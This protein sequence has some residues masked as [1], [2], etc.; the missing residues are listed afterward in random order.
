MSIVN[1][2]LSVNTGNGTNI[3]T[4]P[5]SSIKITPVVEISN[6]IPVISPG[7]PTATRICVA[8]EVLFLKNCS[9]SIQGQD[10]PVS[11][12]FIPNIAGPSYPKLVNSNFNLDVT[13]D[14]TNIS[15]LD[16]SGC[17]FDV[18]NVE[19]NS[20]NCKFIGN[21]NL[22]VNMKNTQFNYNGSVC[23]SSVP[24]VQFTDLGGNTIFIHQLQPNGL[25]DLVE[26]INILSTANLFVHL[27]A[28]HSPYYLGTVDYNYNFVLD[29]NVVITNSTFTQTVNF[30]QQSY[31]LDFSGCIFNVAYDDNVNKY[32]CITN[33][34]VK[35]YNQCI[36][37]PS[38]SMFNSGNLWNFLPSSPSNPVTIVGALGLIIEISTGFYENFN[39][40]NPQF[41]QSG[42]ATFRLIGGN[43]AQQYSLQLGSSNSGL[44]QYPINLLIDNKSIASKFNISVFTVSS[45]GICNT[46]SNV[47]VDF[48][49][50]N[51]NNLLNQQSPILPNLSP[52]SKAYSY[53]LIDNNSQNRNITLHGGFINNGQNIISPTFII[54]G[55]SDAQYYYQNSNGVIDLSREHYSLVN[56]SVT[57]SFQLLALSPPVPISMSIPNQPLKEIQPLMKIVQLSGQNN[58]GIVNIRFN[59]C[60]FNDVM[61]LQQS[62]NVITANVTFTNTDFNYTKI[63]SAGDS[64]TIF[65][66]ATNNTTAIVDISNCHINVNQS[67]LFSFTQSIPQWIVGNGPSTNGGD[68]KSYMKMEGCVVDFSGNE[69]ILLDNNTL[70]TD[71]LF[72]NNTLNMNTFYSDISLNTILFN[73]KNRFDASNIININ[74]SSSTLAY[75]NA[76]IDYSL[77]LAVSKPNVNVQFNHNS[78]NEFVANNSGI[79]AL[80]SNVLTFNPNAA[81]IIQSTTL[82]STNS[83]C[84]PSV[85]FKSNIV[86]TSFC[87][88][89]ISSNGGISPKIIFN[90]ATPTVF[91]ILPKYNSEKQ[92]LTMD[93]SANYV[94]S[95]PFSY[96]L[97]PLLPEGYKIILDGR[98]IYDNFDNDILVYKNNIRNLFINKTVATIGSVGSYDISG[99]QYYYTLNFDTDLGANSPTVNVTLPGVIIND[100]N[101]SIHTV[102]LSGNV[103]LSN[104]PSVS[105]LDTA[106]MLNLQSSSKATINMN[107]MTLSSLGVT[108]IPIQKL[109]KIVN[110]SPNS[111]VSTSVMNYR[112]DNMN[113]IFQLDPILALPNDP[114]NQNYYNNLANNYVN[115][116]ATRNLTIDTTNNTYQGLL[117]YLIINNDSV[118]LT[119]NGNTLP[120]LTTVQPQYVYWPALN[121]IAT[122]PNYTNIKAFT[123][124]AIKIAE[125]WEINTPLDIGNYLGTNSDS[126][127]N[128]KY[129]KLNKYGIIPTT[130]NLD[131]LGVTPVVTVNETNGELSKVNVLA[132]VDS[133][134]NSGVLSLENKINNNNT[135]SHTGKL[136]D[137]DTATVNNISNSTN[138]TMTNG[139]LNKKVDFATGTISNN[140]NVLVLFATNGSP[141]LANNV[142]L[143]LSLNSSPFKSYSSF[144]KQTQDQ[145][146]NCSATKG[147]NITVEQYLLSN[148]RQAGYTG[149]SGNIIKPFDP[150]NPNEPQANSN[151]TSI[152]ASSA[153][154]V[155][156]NYDKNITAKYSVSYNYDFVPIQGSRFNFI[157]DVNVDI[158]FNTPF[159]TINNVVGSN[160]SQNIPNIVYKGIDNSQV[161]NTTPDVIVSLNTIP[162]TPYVTSYFYIKPI[163]SSYN[164]STYNTYPTELTRAIPVNQIY[165]IPLDWLDTTYN[166]NNVTTQPIP[167]DGNNVVLPSF[168]IFG[169]NVYSDISYN[170]LTQVDTSFN[171]LTGERIYTTCNYVAVFILNDASP[172]PQASYNINNDITTLLSTTYSNQNPVDINGNYKRGDI[173]FE[174]Y[175][176]P[177]HSGNTAQVY[178]GDGIVYYYNTIYRYKVTMVIN[179]M[180]DLPSTPLTLT[181]SIGGSN[182]PNI[183]QNLPAPAR[184]TASRFNLNNVLIP[185]YI[186][187]HVAPSTNYS[188][189]QIWND[190]ST[191]NMNNISWYDGGVNKPPYT[192]TLISSGL[193]SGSLKP[194]LLNS[195]NTFDMTD[196]INLNMNQVLN[197][198]GNRN[199]WTNGNSN[200]LNNVSNSSVKN[201]GSDTSYIIYGINNESWQFTPTVS[202]DYIVGNFNILATSDPSCNSLVNAQYQKRTSTYSYNDWSYGNPDIDD[203]GFIQF[204]VGKSLSQ[205]TS[206]ETTTISSFDLSANDTYK[207]TLQNSDASVQPQFSVAATSGQST[208][209]PYN[210]FTKYFIAFNTNMAGINID[211]NNKVILANPTITPD[212]AAN[213][214][215]TFIFTDNN[216][217]PVS[218]IELYYGDN[219]PPIK[220]TDNKFVVPLDNNHNGNPSYKWYNDGT[221]ITPNMWQYVFFNRISYGPS[222]ETDYSNL[223]VN[224]TVGNASGNPSNTKNLANKSLVTVDYSKVGLVSAN[225]S[226]VF[227][228][229]WRIMPSGDGQSLLFRYATA[230]NNPYDM[231]L[232]LDQTNTSVSSTTYNNGTLRHISVPLPGI[233]PAQP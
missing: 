207:L 53:A 129:N 182:G 138:I 18:D 176:T 153:N 30:D 200:G 212:P 215:I 177:S 233:N 139:W 192:I 55:A 109:V 59:N 102:N 49:N 190:A 107:S 69:T 54:S 144:Y 104:S 28:A 220:S 230:G 75:T 137:G 202:E 156:A 187:I 229:N 62:T 189:N 142:T 43:A 42:N 163:L 84:F 108:R 232:S 201:N 105:I 91:N 25:N 179:N 120:T 77:K 1:L 174:R 191:Y 26:P 40:I 95:I 60:I 197:S 87:R 193:L 101:T 85:N 149:D 37:R 81:T 89:Y 226:Q 198:T 195:N 231:V 46:G 199:S 106:M 8:Y 194:L 214:T 154:L 157:G 147:V 7:I 112:Y 183:P 10:K 38:A 68:T 172:S 221:P 78:I 88:Q 71:Y 196:I 100:T 171:P 14:S 184:T 67:N 20:S 178:P 185:L 161:T 34:N 124:S 65:N 33:G 17:L 117:K 19:R 170:K 3:Y 205:T 159:F 132:V 41:Q 188:N 50:M 45:V 63:I 224:Y 32:E 208:L 169:V 74:N 16:M 165:T 2:N 64:P 115:M 94:N 166:T 151:K 5:S 31:L 162:N 227:L 228:G 218:D 146:V 219:T 175:D 158:S 48:T 203:N 133:V 167:T 61:W 145:T 136:Y 123:S 116:V 186:D 80:T 73:A 52:P 113:A 121:Y 15:Q 96:D 27:V 22:T 23:I 11:M 150:P 135:T 168:P 122:R 119:V 6:T 114:T 164:V 225:M 35:F 39:S 148:F 152:V 72:K 47:A 141:Y 90:Q 131:H 111:S 51:L 130:P 110:K 76:N 143:S 211:S 223:K 204:I 36:I 222:V 140:A 209:L 125:A 134:N 97:F 24:S 93:I 83:I 181:Y 173:K 79:L 216:G 126:A 210:K 127:Y 155:D 12:S 128:T 44:I 57:S 217:N 4:D 21:T 58:S 66:L 103:T 180:R 213:M 98:G 29:A 70:S 82:P 160:I 86:N 92:T 13:I 9:V 99:T 118:V 206:L 56:D